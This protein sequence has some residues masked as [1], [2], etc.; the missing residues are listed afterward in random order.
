MSV[1]MGAISLWS[2]FSILE[3]RWSGPAPLPGF[4]FESYF[5]TLFTLIF[6]VGHGWGYELAW[7]DQF[8]KVF[9]F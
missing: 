4:S 8:S 7:K 6:F 3:V 1:S 5:D 2:S 9:Q